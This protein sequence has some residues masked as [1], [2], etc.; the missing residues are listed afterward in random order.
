MLYNLPKTLTLCLYKKVFES[1]KDVLVR[2][3]FHVSE[4]VLKKQKQKI[5]TEIKLDTNIQIKLDVEAP[6]ASSEY[7]ELGYDEVKKMNVTCAWCGDQLGQ[8]K[9]PHGK[10]THGMCDQCRIKTLIEENSNYA[11]H[12][13]RI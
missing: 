4:I 8:R 9:G 5:K 11:P 1:E 3:Q 2:N 6:D 13:N 12:W 10:T 7:L